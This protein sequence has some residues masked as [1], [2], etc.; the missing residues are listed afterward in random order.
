MS[1]R[2]RSAF[3]GIIVWPAIGSPRRLEFCQAANVILL[4][5]CAD[6]RSPRR[7]YRPIAAPR[8]RQ[9]PAART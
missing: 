5:G 7:A 6:E 9:Y 3:K 4:L 2:V 1:T 8:R